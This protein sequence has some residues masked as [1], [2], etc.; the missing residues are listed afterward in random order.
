M[1]VSIESPTIHPVINRI[2]GTS[3]EIPC[4]RNSPT[5]T[6][7]IIDR[8]LAPIRSL[9]LVAGEGRGRYDRNRKWNRQPLPFSIYWT[10]GAWL[11]SLFNRPLCPTAYPSN[12]RNI[13]QRPPICSEFRVWWVKYSDFALRKLKSSLETIQKLTNFPKILKAN[14]HCRSSRESIR[15]CRLKKRKSKEIVLR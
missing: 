9:C 12:R 14:I 15:I 13:S 7:A 3:N 8:Q 5:G 11:A 6:R 10:E 4:P 2:K 1:S